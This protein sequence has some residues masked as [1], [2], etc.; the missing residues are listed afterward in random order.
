MEPESKESRFYIY[1]D[2]KQ[3]GF[4]QKEKR[5]NLSFINGQR[6]FPE[7]KNSGFILRVKTADLP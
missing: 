4:N 6:I 5:M 2:R 7:S 3:S 1:P